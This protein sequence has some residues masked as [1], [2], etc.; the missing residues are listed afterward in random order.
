METGIPKIA[1][2]TI[3]LKDVTAPTVV[4]KPFTANLNAT[5]MVSIVPANVFQSGADNC[6]TV[7]L[8]SV[9]PN[10][11]TCSNIGA[12][13]VTLTVNDG[14]GNNATCNAIVTVSDV[15]APVAKCKDITAN[16]GV[17]G[18]VTVAP[19]LVNNG[20]TDNCSFTLTLTPNTFNCSNVGIVNTVV[21][22]ATDAGG[23]SATCT[24]KVTVKDLLGPTAKCKNPTIFLDALG[25]ATLSAAQVNNGS[26]DACGIA[27][28]SINDT[29]FN[30]S[31]L[32]GSPWPVT[33]SLSDVNGNSSSCLAYVTVKDAIAPTAVCEDVTV[34]LGPSGYAVVYCDDLTPNSTDN[35]AVWSCSPT[36]KV[37]TTANLGNNNL[38]VTVKDYSNNSST[39]VSVVTVVPYGTNN[40]FQQGGGGKG[41]EILYSHD[42]LV[43]PNPTSGDAEMAFQLPAD[44]SFVCRIFDTSGRMVYSHEDRGVEGENRMTLRLEG[45]APGLYVVDFQSEEWRSPETFGNSGMIGRLVRNPKPVCHSERSE[46]PEGCGV[47]PPPGSSLRSE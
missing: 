44:Q 37:Y 33:L 4:C 17:N 2:F 31:E 13:L 26:T 24:A 18:T 8:A 36:A 38:T 23:N 47:L 29:Q 14:N 41:H 25:Q 42:L 5:G 10:S 21:L 20:T 22:R 7:N 11:F 39:C 3:T 45:L 28:M 43:F 19:S 35:C 40:D 32:A 6:G 1:T 16:L 12:N 46:E 15:T 34:A 9:T 30:C 27:T